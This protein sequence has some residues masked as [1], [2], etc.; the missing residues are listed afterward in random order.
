MD[1]V[2]ATVGNSS[3]IVIA[4]RGAS[5]YRP[6]HTLE[7][8]DLAITLGAD[9][10]EPDLVSTSDGVLVARHENEISQTTDIADH[11]EF[12]DRRTVKQIDYRDMI[13]WFTEDF[14]FAELKTLRVKE[15][16]PSLRAGN[17]NYDGQFEI[18]SLDE[19]IQLAQARS[20][21]QKPIGIYPETKHPW[22]FDQLGLPLE[23]ML[24]DRLDT[25]G[26]NHRAAPVFIQSFEVYNLKRMREI[27]DVPLVQLIGDLAT[28]TDWIIAQDP[29]TYADM[30]TP[31]GLKEISTYADG[32]GPHRDLLLPPT[33]GGTRA[34]STGVLESAHG[35]GLRVHPWTFRAEN[36]YL[37]PSLRNGT[38][39]DAKGDLRADIEQYV[40]LGVDGI[41][42]DFPDIA[43]SAIDGHLVEL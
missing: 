35:L 16:I 9:F 12:A 11:P 25:Y 18:A 43:V 5:G 24:L 6:E 31:H 28:P 36:A 26:L 15:R 38:A 10:I 21:N 17:A 29:R 32:I 4:H 20:T 2:D 39:P 8:Y 1:L 30:C 37:Q 13:G 14:T 22:Y 7:A 34:N 40:D 19:I 42:C 41:F 23:P 33:R 27:T 3:P